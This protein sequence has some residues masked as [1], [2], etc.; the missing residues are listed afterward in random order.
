MAEEK[1]PKV[2]G[3]VGRRPMAR[4][5]KFNNYVKKKEY[6]SSVAEIEDDTFDCGHSKYAAKFVKSLENVANYIQHTAMHGGPDIGRVVR[7]MQDINVADIA[8]PDP[9]DIIAVEKWKMKIHKANKQQTLIDENKQ[10]AYAIVYN[11]C[12]PAM[13][14]ELKGTPGMEDAAATQ[15]VVKL[16]NLIQSI[17]SEAGGSRQGV[18]SLVQGKKKVDTFY[19]RADQTNDD[20]AEELLALVR[21]VETYGGAYGKEPGIIDAVLKDSGKTMMAASADQKAAAEAEAR[22][23]YVACL[24]IS[25]ADNGRYK[26]LKDDLHNHYTMGTDKYPKTVEG[27]IKLL[28]NYKVTTIRGYNP[29]GRGVENV[30]M[31]QT[32]KKGG[33]KK[34]DKTMKFK[35]GIRCFKCN[36]EGHYANDCEKYHAKQAEDGI[37][38]INVESD[39]DDY[40]DDAEHELQLLSIG[41]ISDSD[42]HGICLLQKRGTLDPDKFYLDTCATYSSCINQEYLRDMKEMK[43]GLHGH[44]NAGTTFTNKR[45]Y[46]GSLK[47]WYNPTGIA[48]LISFDQLEQLYDITYCTRGTKKAFI[49]HTPDGDVSFQRDSMG[50]PYIDAKDMLSS[51][52]GICLINT[53]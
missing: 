9:N 43:K 25:G 38:N 42:E 15:D 26:Q 12:S 22:E 35:E 11:Q 16:L 29:R 18:M 20:Y 31:I 3:T 30:A 14:T 5:Q 2:E 21:V 24:I 1:K 40:D 6:K 4:R 45:G 17:C 19:Q 49:V 8:D 46:F 36:E 28:N 13:R 50:L 48:N 41:G 53:I 44:C 51:K 47:M 10:K 37:V 34:E 32:D 7:E 23:R 27:A 52:G 39:D 33:K